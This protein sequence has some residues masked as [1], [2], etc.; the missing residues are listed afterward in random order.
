[1]AAPA[2]VEEYLASLPEGPRRALEGLRRA[3]RAAAPE[4]T[5]S[6][7]YQMP[8]FKDHG[9]SLVAYAAFKDHCSFFPMSLG[10]MEA[11]RDELAAFDTSKG[12]IRFPAERPLPAE[13]VRRM[14]QARL[15]ESRA[16]RR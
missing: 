14:V 2:S 8:G 5:E 3:I 4:A 1:M 11:F 9:R 12:T 6:I 10:V 16:R 15:R 13:L 7:V